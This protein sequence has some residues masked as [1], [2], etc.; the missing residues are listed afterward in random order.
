MP[1]DEF[2]P[3]TYLNYQDDPQLFSRIVDIAADFAFANQT[4]HAVFIGRIAHERAVRKVL[5]QEHYFSVQG[6]TGPV[7]VFWSPYL[8]DGQ[9]SI[10]MTHVLV[11]RRHSE[12]PYALRSYR[13]QTYCGLDIQRFGDGATYMELE[14]FARSTQHGAEFPFLCP[15]CKRY[16]LKDASKLLEVDWRVNAQIPEDFYAR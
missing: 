12:E 1:T 15:A 13:E 14:P 9:I 4:L 5:P 16:L 8:R 3:E 10:T 2:T 11:H 7:R 6:P